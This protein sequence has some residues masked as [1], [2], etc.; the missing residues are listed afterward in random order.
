[1][2]QFKMPNLPNINRTHHRI[3]WPVVQFLLTRKTRS[4]KQV[5]ISVVALC[6]N[7][8]VGAS[9]ECASEERRISLSIAYTSTKKAP[10]ERSTLYI[11]RGS[12][13]KK[14]YH[15]S[16]GYINMTTAHQAI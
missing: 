2:S 13:E 16:V 14:L 12:E 5:P 15:R 3:L 8:V 11:E 7:K 1:M 6:R 10:R 4:D 9:S